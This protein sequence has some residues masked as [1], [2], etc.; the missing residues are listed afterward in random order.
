MLGGLA[1][2]A[3]PI[4]SVVGGLIGAAGQHSANRTNIQ[5]A[6]EQMNFQERMSNTAVQ[7]RMA[8]LKKSGINP[9]LAGKF[10]ATTP[11]GALASVGNVGAAGVSSAREGAEAARTARLQKHEETLLKREEEKKSSEIG[12]NAKQ[13][14]KILEETNNIEQMR[15]YIYEQHRDLKRTN[16]FYQRNPW[17]IGLQQLGAPISNL[18][19]SAV[20][21]AGVTRLGRMSQRAQSMRDARRRGYRFDQRRRR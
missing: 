13:Q 14:G 16:D 20:G 4:A 7:R 1:P 8:D 2:F 15:K 19:N 6:R 11:A 10:D 12:V 5:M 18:V 3:G 21:A 9:I 17:A